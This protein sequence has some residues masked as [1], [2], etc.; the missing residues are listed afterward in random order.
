MPRRVKSRFVFYPKY[1]IYCI[2]DFHFRKFAEQCRNIDELNLNN[3]KKLTD[4]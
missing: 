1:S 3:C 4:A 2:F